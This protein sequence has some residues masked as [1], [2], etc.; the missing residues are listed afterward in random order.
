MTCL[1]NNNNQLTKITSDLIP[2]IINFGDPVTIKY[3]R[4]KLVS[5]KF[6]IFGSSQ[7]M[8]VNYVKT[9]QTKEKTLQS[10]TYYDEN[11]RPNKTKWYSREKTF[12]IGPFKPSQYGNPICYYNPGYQG[13]DITINTQMWEIDK[14]ETINNTTNVISTCLSLGKVTPYAGYFELVDTVVGFGG[15]IITNSIK[16]KELCQEHVLELTNNTIFSGTYVCLPEIDLS[17]LIARNKV[18]EDYYIED[19]VL[20]KKDSLI[21]YGQTYFIL[22]ISKNK[23]SDLASFDYISSSAELLTLFNSNDTNFGNKFNETMTSSYDMELLNKINAAYKNGDLDLAKA[24]YQH[25]K[26]NKLNLFVEYLPFLTP[27]VGKN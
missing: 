14:K 13:E 10:V 9:I 23:R 6:D 17:N 22:K 12:S 7:V 1:I 4:I 24:L 18:I 19:N 20:V 21:E 16:H 2:N 5:S 27:T 8:I 26:P 3:K 25:I 15:K 11:A